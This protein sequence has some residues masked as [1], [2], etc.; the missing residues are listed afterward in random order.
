MAILRRKPG[1]TGTAATAPTGKA[2]A[3]AGADAFMS[4]LKSAEAPAGFNIVAG[5]YEALLY[6]ADYYRDDKS[7]RESVYLEFVI[8]NDTG[9]MDGKTTRIYYNIKDKDGA[10]ATGYDYLKR[11]LDTLGFDLNQ[12]KSQEEFEMGLKAWADEE[13]PYVVID[14]KKN[15]QYTNVYLNSVMDDQTGKPDMPF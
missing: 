8:V 4:R 15:G 14:V 7:P 2:T 10:D 13:K 1:V 11:D 12:F 6:L 3:A 9:K 5:Q